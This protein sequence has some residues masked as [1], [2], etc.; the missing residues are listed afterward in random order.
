MRIW[1]SYYDAAD[2]RQA[3]RALL[4]FEDAEAVL[5]RSG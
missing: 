4:D 2:K 3:I 5:K 1:Q